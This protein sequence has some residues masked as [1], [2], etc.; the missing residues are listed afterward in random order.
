M[1]S[2]Q[3][4][5]DRQYGAALG[6]APFFWCAFALVRAPT[7]ELL[8]PLADPLRFLLPALV[9]P[10]LEEASFRGLLQPILWRR[11][12]G[13]RQ[14]HGV[15]AANVVTAMLFSASHLLWHSGA[16]ALAVLLPGLVFGYF[17]DRYGRIAPS[18]ALHIF[19]NF[20]F[21][22]LFTGPAL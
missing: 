22:W 21:V 20:G 10:V 4:L 18:V 3:V 7:P 16:Q 11:P 2:L 14:W 9:Y 5:R 19:Y 1:K 13:Q 8:W 17:R 12:W 15:S 6:A